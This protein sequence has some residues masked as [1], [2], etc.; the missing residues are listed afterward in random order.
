VVAEASS[1]IK[2]LRLQPHLD[3]DVEK[4]VGVVW[5]LRTSPGWGSQDRH[6][7]SSAVIPSSSSPG[8][9]WSS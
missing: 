3:G 6:G 2:Y 9:M 7:A 4:L 5:F 1:P 8:R